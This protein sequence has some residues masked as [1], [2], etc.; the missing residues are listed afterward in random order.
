[1]P[2]EASGPLCEER[3]PLDWGNYTAGIEMTMDIGFIMPRLLMYGV[4]SSEKGDI[5]SGEFY[6][7]GWERNGTNV[8]WNLRNQSVGLC[9][10]TNLPIQ[11]N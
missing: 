5:A 9:G 6:G 1:M 11:S 3:M 8:E 7:L 2:L 4:A 10:M